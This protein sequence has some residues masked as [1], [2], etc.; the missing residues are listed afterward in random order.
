MGANNRNGTYCKKLD[1]YIYPWPNSVFYVL[2]D[3]SKCG[4]A[5]TLSNIKFTYQSTEANGSGWIYTGTYNNTSGKDIQPLLAIKSAEVLVKQQVFEVP[6]DILLT[7]NVTIDKYI[8]KVQHVGDNNNTYNNDTQRK[9]KT[10]EWKENNSVKVERG[11]KVTFKIVLKNS[12]NK[13]VKVKIRDI[14]PENAG[15][16]IDKSISGWVEIP[17]SGENTITVDVIVRED[18]SGTLNNTAK[19]ITTN[20]GNIS[21]DSKEYVRVVGING[22]VVNLAELDNN[23]KTEDSD[24]FTIKKYNVNVNKSI[25]KVEHTSNNQVIY[26]GN[27]RKNINE[28]TKSYNPVYVE[29]GDRITYNIDINNT[30]S[31]A[32]PYWN[33][34]KV[35]VN[36]EETLPGKY[37]DLKISI[38][39]E[40]KSVTVTNGKFKLEKIPVPKNGTTTVTVSL[41]I[42]ESTKGL[43]KQNQVKIT[44][45]ILNIN[46]YK[47]ENQSSKS[48]TSDYYRINN[49]NVGI[50]KYINKYNKEMTVSNNSDEN[51]FTNETVN[52]TGRY[53]MTEDEKA[54]K[55]VAV[56]KTETLTYSIVLKN[57]SVTTENTVTTSG[58]KPATSVRT[59]DITEKLDDGLKYKSVYAKVYKADNS[60]KYNKNI[61]VSAVALEN[62]TYKLTI[63][64]DV[65]L[66]PGEKIVYYVTVEVTKNNMYLYSLA[67]TGT[68]TTLTNINHT[69]TLTR[70]VTQQNVSTK[71][72]SK[73][74]VKLKDL[75][76]SGK[77]WLDSDKDGYIGKNASGKL[78]SYINYTA[79]PSSKVSDPS[80]DTEYAIKGITVKL[81]S[82]S[83]GNSTLVRTTKTN[84]KGAFTFGK[85]EDGTTWYPGTYSYNGSVLESEQ[86]I[87]KATN[88]DTNLNYTDNSNYIQYYIEY[89]YDGVVYKSTEVY[90]G[91][92]NLNNDGTFKD[93]YKVDSNAT[94]F[95]D[96][97]KNFNKD[98]EVISYNKARN[99]ALENPS[100]LEYKKNYHNSYLK[101]NSSRIMTARSFIIDNNNTQTTKYLWLYKQGD[102]TNKP[103]TEYL[104]YIN[105]GLEEREDVDLSVV[106]DIY[107]IH[108]T[109]N[110]E[111]MI[112]EFNQN[113]YAK[114]GSNIDH[115]I[116]ATEEFSNN[117]Y[118]TGFKNYKS[119]ITPYEFQYY[120]SDYN[121]KVE[122]NEVKAIQDYKTKDS[123][124]NSEVTF[125]IRVSNNAIINDE[126]YLA[127]DKKD[128]KVYSGIN[129][130]IEYFDNQFM[131]IEYNEDGTVKTINVKTKDDNG[132]L[133]DTP[134]KIADAKFVLPSGATIPATMEGY[135][136]SNNP[137]VLSNQSIYNE[138]RTIA[139][140][141]AVYIRPQMTH[142]RTPIILAEG[143]NVDILIKFTVAKDENRNLELGLKTAIAEIGAY[144]TYYKNADGTY[145]PAGLVDK[146]SNPGNFGDIYDGIGFDINQNNKS[147]DPYLA[148]YEN[149]TFKTGIK[150]TIHS[151]SGDPDDPNYERTIEGQVWDDARSNIAKT[152]DGKDT[153]DGVQYIGDGRN[154]TITGIDNKK[155]NSNAKLNTIFG[156]IASYN[157]EKQEENDFTVNDVRVKL[158]EIVKIP[159]YDAS[160]KITEERIYEQTIAVNGDK[161]IVDSR[162]SN[163]GKYLLKGYIPGEYIVKFFYG[164]TTSEQMTIFNG[165]DYK[166]TTYQNGIGQN[167]SKGNKILTYADEAYLKDSN[168]AIKTDALGNPKKDNDKVLAILETKGLSDA[169]DDEIRRLETISYSETLENSKT[170]VLRGNNS[171]NKE[172]QIEKT[173]MNSETTDFL[174]RAEK[175][176]KS[177]TKLTYQETKNKMSAVKRNP[178]QNIDFGLQYRP[179][180]QVG[181]NKFIKNITIRTSDS[182]SS[183]SSELVNVKFN[184]YY[185]IVVN[186]DAVTGVTTYLGYKKDS[187]NSEYETIRIPEE[188]LSGNKANIELYVQNFLNENGITERDLNYKL[189]QCVLNQDGS[190]QVIIAGT[191]MDLEKSIGLS[192]LQYV[193]NSKD[194][195]D[196][197]S[198]QG[199]IYLNIDDN[200]MQGTQVDIE[201]IFTGHNLSEIDR[202]NKNLSVLRLKDNNAVS[203]YTK[204]F[205][206]DGK[207]SGALTARDYLYNKY[208]K[209]DENNTNYRI[210]HFT[211][212]V[213]KDNDYYGSYLGSVYYTGKV[214]VSN[215]DSNGDTIAELKIDQIL[216]Y[217]DNNLVFKQE[218]NQKVNGAWGTITSS[219]L[220]LSGKVS[221]SIL[222][223]KNDQ[224]KQKLDQYLEEENENG[225]SIDVIEDYKTLLGKSLLLDSKGVSYNT[226]ERSNLAIMEDGRT[227]DNQT[228][229][230]RNFD[231]TK[232]LSPR[233]SKGE[234]SFGKI[235]INVSRTISA[236]DDTSNMSYENIGEIIQ[237]SS[238]TG[239]VTNL[240]TTL[241]N[242]KVKNLANSYNNSSEY[243]GAK[244][245]SDTAAVEKI[246]LTPPTGLNKTERIITVAVKGA[247][248]VGIVIVV[249]AIIGLG[250]FAGIK[251]YRKRRIK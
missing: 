35:Y 153:T 189:N 109:I 202:V 34:D 225:L 248:Y 94:E 111:E 50:N 215:S 95:R 241:G 100:T 85:K 48:D 93:K 251:I 123:E 127:N 25:V 178:I 6:V 230:L 191:E 47:I 37:S 5:T 211:V 31:N 96:V 165:Q 147:V 247:S 182:T 151:E 220:A 116:T 135:N 2:V 240:K 242:A 228:E 218:D 177:K 28:S 198:I 79:N 33:P 121:Y 67:N 13:A 216:D 245:E 133:V 29:Y 45:D 105:L 118:M 169:K 73:D 181:L 249:I 166:S 90:S 113:S 1:N 92:Q 82:V 76:I 185:G 23:K 112:Y 98:Y 108:N 167:D 52:F 137:L 32:D 86:R 36:I 193:P 53:N 187:G 250:I 152:I 158:V 106:Q 71:V 179:E 103:D 114:G 239:R 229:N 205:T 38:G 157:N 58:S 226:S 87:P 186:T 168:S 8:T 55:P 14:L 244:K 19:I 221:S 62:N 64:N 141:N 122:Q 161:S 83:G 146:N 195:H 107:E 10:I 78:N 30:K 217:V 148:L 18:S 99:G 200:I 3:K 170:L 199:F 46:N 119:A 124:L 72:N 163:G 20:K 172:L 104:K 63:G 159:K 84:E 192:N 4:S 201:Y 160:G 144:S 150:L 227:S 143:E 183:T 212:G 136:T 145:Y 130:V 206:E 126:P 39:D 232:Y 134:F 69:N 42:E 222:E 16:T 97:R 129:E 243:E 197:D 188:Y 207:Y 44:G 70:N 51:K 41:V 54:A 231:I 26:N 154:G 235:T 209:T 115:D 60:D 173:S 171:I 91:M 196:V 175:E 66:E 139:G 56:E 194:S 11:D 138:N 131:N 12:S 17:A 125:R 140:Y 9:G 132:Y 214:F 74:F 88:K 65:I 22:P 238:V 117:L 80:G 237:Y 155:A 21:D 234:K 203:N 184:E 174:V 210:K 246:T 49:Y 81:Y 102:N 164:D 213:N 180:Q 233:D 110:G 68:I 43:T 40:E 224:D 128:I 101:I 219:E 190:Y 27:D 156:T 223:F 89:E 57:N 176:D 149:D 77:V 162:T 204:A 142:T 208:Y 59:T 15:Y 75:V 61:A 24:Y 120:L 7:T 236:Q